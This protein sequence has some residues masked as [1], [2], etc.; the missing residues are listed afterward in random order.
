MIP[1]SVEYARKGGGTMTLFE[2]INLMLEFGLFIIAF[3]TLIISI[4]KSII[5]K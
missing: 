3:I 1:F 2:S 5:K 4:I